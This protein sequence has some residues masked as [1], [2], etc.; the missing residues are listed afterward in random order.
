MYL[1]FAYPYLIVMMMAAL[2]LRQP[3]LASSF[4]APSIVSHPQLLQQ[5]QR[6][7]KSNKKFEHLESASSVFEYEYIPPNTEGS[8][9]NFSTNLPSVYPPGTPAG[10]RGE[11]VRAALQSGQCLAWQLNQQ[12]ASPNVA[13]GLLQLQGK[14]TLEFLNNKLSNSF[15]TDTNKYSYSNDGATISEL[16]FSQAC[17]LTP[18]GRLVDI[19]AIA[20]SDELA[21]LVP[22]P[23]HAGSTLYQRLDPFIFPMDQVKLMDLSSSTTMFTLVSTASE[24]VHATLKSQLWPKLYEL[25]GSNVK[26]PSVDDSIPNTTNDSRL[27][28]L[29]S[30]GDGSG[31]QLLV[32]PS[33]ELPECACV[34]YTFAFLNDSHGIGSGLWQYLIGQDNP[35]GPVEIQG[36]EYEALRI[37]AG[38]PAF[39][40]EV[41]GAWKDLTITSPT[42]LELH[43]NSGVID[44][45]KGCYLGQEGIASVM[46]NPRGPPRLL[47]SVVFEDDDNIYQHQSDGDKSKIDNLTRM[48]KSGDTLFVLGSNEEIQVGTLTSVAEPYGTGDSTIVSLALVRRPDSILKQM[49]AKDLQIP[50]SL[51]ATLVVGADAA[52]QGSGFIP[53]PPIDSLDGL[54]VI[55]GGSFTV[56]ML[57]SVPTRRLPKGKNMFADQQA[58][59]TREEILQ[60]GYVDIEFSDTS[61]TEFID[62][63]L[64]ELGSATAD[65]EEI[66]PSTKKDDLALTSNDEGEA[67]AEAKRN[68]AKVEALKK[69]A[70]EAMARRK[71]K[72]LQAQSNAVEPAPKSED[73]EAAEAKRKAEKLRILQQRAEDA[74]ARRKKKKD[75]Q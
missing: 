69:R 33:T 52:S 10:M 68:A 11:A 63:N 30:N 37:E 9:H 21:F 73:E 45:N 4:V 60:Q 54:E 6:Q 1:V 2:S 32:V 20:H 29:D 62:E 17:L 28:N 3:F 7:A 39:G 42:P 56:G 47:Y 38:Q 25:G 64:L 5:L 43:K 27:L 55:V 22:S 40:H 58:V 41:T 24:D 71:Q 74:I 36:L 14:G 8:S 72:K 67:E 15:V 48:P 31:L 49:K 13:A 61:A 35:K 26:L 50:R 70:D 44:V 19:L 12:E 57:R 23:G 18:K 75:Q 51:G 16:T 59:L 65:K 34:G 53:P 46:K 66:E